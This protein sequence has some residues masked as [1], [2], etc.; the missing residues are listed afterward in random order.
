M[1][2]RRKVRTIL[3]F[4]LLFLLILLTGL[5]YNWKL[6]QE[7][8]TPVEHTERKEG[9]GNA[10]RKESNSEK[11]TEYSPIKGETGATS[12][13]DSIKLMQ[14]GH[15]DHHQSTGAGNNVL[16]GE[17]RSK[18]GRLKIDWLKG[19]HVLVFMHIQ[20]TGGK[21]FLYHAGSV[22]Q[23]NKL[24]CTYHVQSNATIDGRVPKSWRL[25]CPI[26]NAAYYPNNNTTPVKLWPTTKP[27]TLKK[28]K[29]LKRDFVNMKPLPEMWLLSE[30]TYQWPC[31][32]H[33]FL[34]AMPPCV[35]K[36]Y[37]KRYGKRK[38]QFHYF[39]LLRN[40]IERYLSEFLH[41]YEGKASWDVVTGAKE[42][43]GAI[44]EATVPECYRNAYKRYPWYDVNL[45][46]F[47]LCEHN[48]AHNRQTWMLAD[49]RE[50]QCG[51]DGRAAKRKDKV[52]FERELLDSAKKSLRS[53]SFFG[54]AEH[55]RESAL[56]FEYRFN[57]RLDLKPPPIAPLSTSH[58]LIEYVLED[59]MLLDK[60]IKRNILDIQLYEYA[61]KLFKGR[62]KIIGINKIR[63]R[64][65]MYTNRV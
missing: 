54:L 48:W 51:G 34:A 47:V 7:A 49:H 28:R 10:L 11:A 43:P 38:R 17:D 36:L 61:L 58:W 4:I 22:I 41:M 24:L 56:L 5:L 32:I 30:V 15:N 8:N 60:I 2:V 53:M 62:L 21:S 26:S 44:S 52:S 65:A 59:K 12:V 13:Q 57:V 3:V 35:N 46:S 23:H 31:G 33:S 6:T 16:I 42:C 63:R 19:R 37:T 55:M 20:R 45:T 40:P 1:A 64:K 18:W 29:R 9:H 27:L 14:G 39:T 25:V 50:L